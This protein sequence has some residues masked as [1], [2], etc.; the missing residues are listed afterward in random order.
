LE[1]IIHYSEQ[2]GLIPRRFEVDEL[3][4]DATRN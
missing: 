1:L 3:L 2:Q 4:D